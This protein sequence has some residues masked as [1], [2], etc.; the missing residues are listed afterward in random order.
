MMALEKVQSHLVIAS[1]EAQMI[2]GEGNQGGD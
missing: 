1:E 2:L